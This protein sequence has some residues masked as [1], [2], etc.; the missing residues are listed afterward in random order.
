MRG[1]IYDPEPLHKK[2][3]E[4]SG[5]LR[6][7]QTLTTILVPVF[8]VWRLFSRILHSYKSRGEPQA[9]DRTGA[10]RP[11]LSNVCIGTTAAPIF[12][13][14]HYFQEYLGRLPRSQGRKELVSRYNALL[15]NKP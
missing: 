12:F 7:D 6:L 2:I 1:P 13:P 3:K 5:N 8:D 10:E 11:K 4:I 9:E 14:A 15:E